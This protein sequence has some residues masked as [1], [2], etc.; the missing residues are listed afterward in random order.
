MA[1]ARFSTGEVYASY[2]DINRLV[3]PVQVGRFSFP[4]SLEQKVNELMMPLTR[5]GADLI[6]DNLD[7][8]AETMMKKAGFDFSYRRVG[9]YVPPKTRGGECS[10]TLLQDD[11]EEGVTAKMTEAD[12]GAYLTPHNVHVNDWHFTYSGTIVKGLQLERD[13]QAVV[14][15]TPGEWIRLA[16]TALNW[17]I[18]AFG[19]PV[20]GLSYYDL[21]PNGEGGF[22]M[23]LHPDHPI[24]ETMTF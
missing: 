24:L 12:L 16:S 13:R 10:F 15:V 19:T 11:R 2:S 5:E 18:F 14:Y 1:I 22:E 20:I 6:F 7:P 17:P 23:D 3:A 9:C 4:E 8:N 21:E